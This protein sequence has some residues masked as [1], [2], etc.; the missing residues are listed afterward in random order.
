LKRLYRRIKRSLLA[1][2]YTIA[3]ARCDT[4]SFQKQ[5]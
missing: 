3:E 5:I 1:V 4:T 2:V